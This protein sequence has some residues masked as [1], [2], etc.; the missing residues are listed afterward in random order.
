MNQTI[1]IGIVLLIDEDLTIKSR[2]IASLISKQTRV[3]NI[4]G[5]LN[6]PHI[7]LYQGRF[8]KSCIS[9]VK[10]NILQKASSIKEPFWIITSSCN[11]S[12]MRNVFWNVQLN[13]MLS[14]MHNWAINCLQPFSEGDLMPQFK[15]L[16][17]NPNLDQSSK[18][19]IQNYGCLSVKDN[20]Q[21]HITLCHLEDNI[22]FNNLVNINPPKVQSLINFLALGE[23]GEKGNLKKVPFKNKINY[24]TNLFR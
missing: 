9:T 21:P 3:S 5:S 16:L 12:S 24:N 2:Q 8:S 19:R 11:V 23:L 18:A 20:Y 10:T 1:D 6:I 17:A 22:N 15:R 14:H 13:T 4:I 7:T